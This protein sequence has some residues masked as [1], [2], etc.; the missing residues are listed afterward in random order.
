MWPAPLLSCLPPWKMQPPKNQLLVKTSE[1]RRGRVLGNNRWG[2]LFRFAWNPQKVTGVFFFGRS[3]EEFYSNPVCQSFFCVCVCP[4]HESF[5]FYFNFNARFQGLNEL[6]QRSISIKPWRFLERPLLCLEM[7]VKMEIWGDD[8]CGSDVRLLCCM[9]LYIIRYG[10]D[11]IH[12][13]NGDP[14]DFVMS[15]HSA[16]NTEYIARE[17]GES[18]SLESVV[19][20]WRM[21]NLLTLSIESY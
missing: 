12:G 6:F 4:W 11:R 9:Y 15:Q 10:T 18:T 17:R 1:Y 7:E 16:G 20:Y 5:F 8:L 13:F 19:K 21:Q 14:L 3:Q 2:T